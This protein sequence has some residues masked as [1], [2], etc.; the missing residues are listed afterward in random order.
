MNSKKKEIAKKEFG[1]IV[2][3]IR[4]GQH[5]T[6]RDISQN[7]D[8]DNS[9]ISKIENGKMNSCLSTIVELALG[10]G[11]QPSDLLKGQFG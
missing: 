6:V 1:R 3:A 8:L 10:L 9:K 7:C 11:V 5:L 4:Q 2:K